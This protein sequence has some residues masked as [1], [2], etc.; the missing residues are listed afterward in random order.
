MTHDSIIGKTLEFA[1]SNETFSIQV[2]TSSQLKWTRTKGENTGA[3]DTEDYVYSQLTPDIAVMTWIEADGLGLSNAL[4]L[5]NMTVTTHA[6]MGR[7]VF[8]N[9]GA[10]RIT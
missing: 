3:G 1:Y 2:L 4:N 9:A 8:E 6:N 5:S 7:E 10:L